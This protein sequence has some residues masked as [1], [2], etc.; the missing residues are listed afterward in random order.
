MTCKVETLPSV[1][2]EYIDFVRSGEIEC[3]KD[4]FALCDYVEK[5]FREESIYVDEEQL[6]RYLNQQK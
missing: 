6:Q 5:C 3:C 4:Q 1:L 2:Q